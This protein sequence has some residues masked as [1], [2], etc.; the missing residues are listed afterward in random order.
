M[1]IAYLPLYCYFIINNIIVIIITLRAFTC[2][3]VQRIIL[4]AKLFRPTK[5]LTGTTCTIARKWSCYSAYIN[6]A[7]QVD[8]A[9]VLVAWRWLW[10]SVLHPTQ[11]IYYTSHA[12][13]VHTHIGKQLICQHCPL[14]NLV[15]LTATVTEEYWETMAASK[16]Q[17]Q[18]VKDAAERI[19]GKVAKTPLEVCT[20]IKN[21]PWCVQVV[22][23]NANT[24]LLQTQIARSRL[25]PGVNI[26]LKK[27]CL[28]EGVKR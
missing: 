14:L 17:L 20:T 11:S 6:K 16:F 7:F 18:A 2:H 13:T 9:I 26:Y 19:R 5:V 15:A 25:L 1:Y 28:M 23:I 12:E 10:W 4:T 3:F 8:N 21:I 22:K 27:D 24:I